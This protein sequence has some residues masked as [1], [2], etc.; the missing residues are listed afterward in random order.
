M[1]CIAYYC[2]DKG[3]DFAYNVRVMS[4][5][6]TT[7]S[8]AP[9]TSEEELIAV[10][11]EKVEKIRA[12][13]VN[14]YGG[15]FDVTISPAKL[16][17]EFSE[18]QKVRILGRISALRDMGKTQFFTLADVHGS[19]QCMLTQ[20]GVSEEQWSLWKLL[21]RGDWVGVEGETFITRTGEPS[22]RVSEF[23]VLSKALRPMP[24]K[25]HGLVDQDMRYRRRHL[26]LMSN[27]DSAERFVKRSLIIQ[28]IRR[29][30]VDRG[31]LEVETPM[32]QDVAGGAAAKPF[33]SY[34][35]ALKK[36]VTMRIAP[37]LYLKRL[38]VG[39]F[40]KVF[41]MNRNFRNEGVDRTHNPE[42]TALEVYEAGGDY[43]SMA[44]MMED[45]ITTVALKVF[46]TLKFDQYDDHGELRWTVDLT[47]PW[48]RADYG[49]L[50]REVAGADW[51]ELTPEQRRSRA[52]NEL[53]LQIGAEL[54]DVGVTQQV[55]EKLVEEKQANP[56]FVC[57]VARDLVP[58]AKANPDNPE[59][60][61]VFELVM[62]GAE[63]CPGYSEQNDP[64]EQ[65]ERLKHQAGD[66][67]QKIDHDFVATL[68]SGMPS[69]GGIG[70]GIDR[71]CMLLTGVCSI[72]DIILFPQL[73]PKQ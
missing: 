41:E 18:G 59:V 38:M 22:V 44:D 70:I 11:R 4:D 49:D 39:G 29:Y 61:D 7:Q 68:E 60:V 71:L 17:A 30:L 23:K 51:F 31:F 35:N 62:N 55:Y 10:R 9:G 21:E 3:E 19:I 58:L 28:E 56:L 14:P 13:G 15:R 20:K 1:R 12:L 43:E 46:G 25:F 45:M 63:L 48:R 36:P 6:P 8:T 42:F 73:K 34:Y 65:L 24:D 16:K 64:V 66:E 5:T 33:E 52:E 57:H 53:K 50:V 37:E 26:D 27:A 72:R 69:A 40:P 47:R 67:V 2:L 32:L 54:D